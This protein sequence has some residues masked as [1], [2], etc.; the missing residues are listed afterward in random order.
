[1]RILV[2][3][4]QT[5]LASE[6]AKRVDRAGFAVDAVG[7]LS[8][9]RALVEMLAYSITLLD[10]RLPDGDGLSLVPWIQAKRPGSRIL[11]LTALDR[12][13]DRI[14][15]LDAGADDYLVKPFSL[16]ELM[17]RIRALGRRI[18]ELRSPLISVGNLSFDLESQTAFVAERPIVLHRRERA[19]LEALVTRAE[20]VV[21]RTTLISEIYG[22][23]E[24]IQP[25]ALTILVSRLRS[26]LDEEGAAIEIHTTRGVGYMIAT[27][28]A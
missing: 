14:E 4:D 21:R 15:G 17:A 1:M 18:G 25:Q 2:V 26:R 6:I 13:D 12:L 3:E 19:L 11:L 20:R 24:E 23:D 28:L 5:D 10:R 9:A 8:D 27:T 16:D 22:V 7:T